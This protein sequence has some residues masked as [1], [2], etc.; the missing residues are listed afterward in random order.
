MPMIRKMLVSG[1][2]LLALAACDRER[3]M[4]VRT[5]ELHRLTTAEATSLLTPYIREHGM[6][7]GQNRLL[8]V[9]ETPDRLDS[10]AK[11]LR[12]YDGPRQ[13]L[14]LHFQVIEAGDFEGTDPDVARVASPLREMLRYRG[15]RLLSEVTVPALEGQ[16]FVHQ[17]RGLLI[18]GEVEQVLPP[19]DA[20]ITLR[21]GAAAAGARVEAGVSGHPGQT[22][23]LGSGEKQ[24]A[25]GALIVAVRPELG[26]IVAGQPAP[27]TASTPATP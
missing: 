21:V 12:R 26:S 18:E 1:A 11:I 16:P 25:P 15:Y 6:I 27:G 8:T 17:G 14:T 23:V 7:T 2:I 19:P 20:L 9:R 22:M 13:A 10:V 4:Q 24:G 3:G 5:Y